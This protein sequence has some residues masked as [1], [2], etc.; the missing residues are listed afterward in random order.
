MAGHK[1]STKFKKNVNLPYA[2]VGKQVFRSLYDAETYCSENGLDP[3]T[4]ITYGESEELRKEIVEIAKYQKAVLRRV[5]AELEKQ[6]E[7]I[8]NSI[9]RDSERLQHCHPLEEGSFRDKLRDDVAKSTATYDAMEIV[10]KL[11]EQMQWLSNWKD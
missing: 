10:F 8:S 5:Q 7:R 2:K 6:S 9:K 3:D 4:A 11:I 1:Y